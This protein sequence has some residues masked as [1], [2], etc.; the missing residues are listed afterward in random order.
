[1][2]C[3]ASNTDFLYLPPAPEPP[4]PAPIPLQDA[5]K[6]AVT[7]DHQYV[8]VYGDDIKLDVDQPVLQAQGVKLKANLPP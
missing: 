4:P 7:L 2:L 5:L 8:E 1:M 3:V 6:Y